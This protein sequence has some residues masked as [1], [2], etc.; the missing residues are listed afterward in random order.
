M[1]A[2]EVKVFML[3]NGLTARA[4]AKELVDSGVATAT[5]NSLCTMIS[6]MIYGRNYYPTL[7][8]QIKEKFTLQ[9]DRQT[10]IP[11]REVV[12]KAA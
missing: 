12:R 6:D 10:R 3:K 2:F 7:A 4:M 1:N 5:E 9:F 11:A 8:K